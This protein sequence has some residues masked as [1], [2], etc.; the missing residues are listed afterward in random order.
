MDIKEYFEFLCLS[1]G[2]QGLRGIEDHVMSTE[3]DDCCPKCGEKLLT[4]TRPQPDV[5]SLS[6]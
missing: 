1:C 4:I 2:L 5:I 3:A 6:I